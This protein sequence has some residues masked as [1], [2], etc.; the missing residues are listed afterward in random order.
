[1]QEI[2]IK[3]F[4]PNL[5]LSKIDVAEAN[6]RKSQQMAGIEELKAS[7]QRFGLIHPVIV[8]RKGDR[9][10]LIVGQRRYI[11]FEELGRTTIPALIINPVDATAQRIAS[12]GE[13]IHR[14]KLPY[15]DTIRVCEQLYKEYTGPKFE[16]IKKIAKDLGIHPNTVSKYLAYKLIPS[17]VQKLVSEKKLSAKV[18]YR[19][20]SAFWPNSQK[21]IKIARLATRMTKS[22]WERALDYGKRKP[23]ARVEE[24]IEYAKKPPPII[25]IT[26]AMESETAKLLQNVAEQRH[27]DVRDLVKSVIEQWLEEEGLA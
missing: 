10:K 25:E 1:M 16:R 5:P 14:R 4:T 26:I 7:I 20:T 23:D 22:E 12:F 13:N 15:D 24:I 2:V 8:I 27:T 21:I 6:V 3:E 17:E 18:A 11:A 19:I 9:Y